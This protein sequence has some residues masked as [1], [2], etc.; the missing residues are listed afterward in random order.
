MKQQI[1]STFSNE[2]V[3]SSPQFSRGICDELLEE[4]RTKN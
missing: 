3:N 1:I 4:Q 2:N